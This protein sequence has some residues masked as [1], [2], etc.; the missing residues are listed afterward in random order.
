MSTALVTLLIAIAVVLIGGVLSFWGWLAV[1]VID[2]GRKLI[3]LEVKMD[4][5]EKRDDE[6]LLWFSK[7]DESIQEVMV[8]TAACR[9]QFGYDGENKNRRSTDTKT[10]ETKKGED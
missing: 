1:K 3:E 6:H 2:Q 10:S 8:N 7:M 4:N 5:H 9:A